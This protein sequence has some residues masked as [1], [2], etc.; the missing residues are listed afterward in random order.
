MYTLGKYNPSDEYYIAIEIYNDF[1]FGLP[2]LVVNTRTSRV[3]I[4]W[5][6]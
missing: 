4:N 6:R 1:K 2:I 3:I 5:L